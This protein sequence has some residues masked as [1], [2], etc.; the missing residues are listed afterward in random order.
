[1]MYGAIIAAML[2]MT[3][4]GN[5][6]FD[7]FCPTVIIA[8]YFSIFLLAGA[9]FQNITAI[10]IDRLLALSLHLRYQELVTSK[11]VVIV[12]VI[13]WLTSGV[14]AFI[15]IHLLSNN[16]MLAATIELVGLLLS[17]VAYIRIYRIVRYHQN[18]IHCQLQL[19]NAQGMDYLRGK[20]SAFNAL[21][22][23]VVFVPCF[24][25]HLC[26][27]FVLTTASFRISFLVA[28]DASLFLIFLNSS[29]NP[30]VYCWRYREI[31]EIVKKHCEENISY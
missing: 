1:M 17:A 12:L 5:Y 27:V 7:M 31:H 11:R 29:L 15:F 6:N 24:L 21:F 30:V 16:N 14:T 10:A 22:V 8:C 3:A 4:T 2:K 23:Y 20:K 9:I 25:P 26:S 19:T 28:E 13:L 18:Q